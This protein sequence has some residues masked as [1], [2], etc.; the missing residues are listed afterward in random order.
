MPLACNELFTKIEAK[1]ASAKEGEEY[2]VRMMV[3]G[4]PG[5]QSQA[6]ELFIKFLVSNKIAVLVLLLTF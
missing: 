5:V 1:R 2:Q 4:V 3:T 6:S